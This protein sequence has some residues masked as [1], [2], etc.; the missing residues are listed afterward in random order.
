MRAQAG[1]ESTNQEGVATIV[2]TA[3]RAFIGLLGIIFVVL[4]VASGY[5][6]MT[7]GGDEAK[8]TKAKNTI[9]RA[10]I[11]LVIVLAAY[12]ITFFVFSNLDSVIDSGGSASG[13]T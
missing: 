4:I 10:V 2:A 7:A 11:G 9:S 1:F 13:S 5:N 6:W 3:I 8:I 12:S